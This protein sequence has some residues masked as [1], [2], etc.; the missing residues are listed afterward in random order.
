[1]F[2]SVLFPFY[3]V[4]FIDLRKML[5]RNIY[6]CVCVCVCVRARARN[7]LMSFIADESEDD[8]N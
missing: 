5:R 6:F 1:M 2:Y 4:F 8:L 3:I 7:L